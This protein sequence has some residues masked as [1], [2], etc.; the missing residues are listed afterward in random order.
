M[1]NPHSRN[2]EILMA[3]IEGTK[4]SKKPHSREEYLLIKLK[5]L[6]EAGGGGGLTPEQ[7]EELKR[8]I[9][10]E[11][12]ELFEA[13]WFE[14]TRAEWNALTLDEKKKYDLLLF[15]DEQKIYKYDKNHN[16]INVMADGDSVNL[17]RVLGPVE[18]SG[19]STRAYAKGEAFLIRYSD[20]SLKLREA[21]EDIAVGDAL[22]EDDT[23]PGYN[24]AAYDCE[25]LLDA[26]EAARDV[27][28]IPIEEIDE[29]FDNL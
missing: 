1:A 18:S 5:E 21:V 16:R 26:I 15:T 8:Q 2:E 4:Y 19:V 12:K 29:L 11:A 10:E 3:I 28:S 14:G 22:I 20:H 6:I 9:I 7:I 13:I 27:K 17:E 25:T 23:D 24:T